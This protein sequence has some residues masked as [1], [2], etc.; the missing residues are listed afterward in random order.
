MKRGFTLVE[1]LIVIGII[2]V[3]LGL[4]VPALNQAMYVAQL[5]SGSGS[6]KSVAAGAIQYTKNHKGAYPYRPQ[7]AQGMIHPSVVERGLYDASYW[8]PYK[9]AQKN[10]PN[11]RGPSRDVRPHIKS[12]IDID[13]LACPLAGDVDLSD[14]ATQ[15]S[16]FIYSGFN[17]FFG[18]GY[19]SGGGMSRHGNR[20]TV[21]DPEGHEEE[22]SFN[23]LTSDIDLVGWSAT[24]GGGA[25]YDNSHPDSKGALNLVTYQNEGAGQG[26]SGEPTGVTGSWHTDTGAERPRG[27]VDLNYAYDDGSVRKIEKIEDGDERM[28]YVPKNDMESQYMF[29]QLPRPK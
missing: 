8:E 20:W 19:K 1:L 13:D 16:N 26:E 18:F 28:V 24:E 21:I 25:W 10:H 23:I 11:T 15:E 5:L 22:Y 6:Q 12:Y 27:T 4:L 14:E 29:I 3:L 7:S 9:L 2:V 17:L